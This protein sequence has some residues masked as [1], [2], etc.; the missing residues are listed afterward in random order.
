MDRLPS[1]RKQLVVVER[2]ATHPRTALL[3]FQRIP[4]ATVERLKL[5]CH[6]GI[7]VGLLACHTRHLTLCLCNLMTATIIIIGVGHLLRVCERRVLV[8]GFASVTTLRIVRVHWISDPTRQVVLRVVAHRVV[9]TSLAVRVVRKEFHTLCVILRIGAV[10][11]CGRQLCPISGID[12][13][14]GATRVRATA[15]TRVATRIIA[16]SGALIAGWCSL[17]FVYYKILLSARV[18]GKTRITAIVL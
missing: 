14:A 15:R 11:A 4:F 1:R 5:R 18:V 2:I 8:E 12:S 17:K 16:S 13:R 3:V 7:V 10:A 6:I 9:A